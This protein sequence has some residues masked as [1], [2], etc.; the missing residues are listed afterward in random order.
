MKRELPRRD[1]LRIIA[2][3]DCIMPVGSISLKERMQRELGGR[4]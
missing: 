1:F 4:C 2:I 3:N